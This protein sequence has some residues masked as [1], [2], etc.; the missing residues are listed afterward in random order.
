MVS[1]GRWI[2][3]AVEYLPSHVLPAATRRSRITPVTDD[4]RR[5]QLRLQRCVTL[6]TS[7]VVALA[8]A[9]P[10]KGID[11][12]PRWPASERCFG[13]I[14]HFGSA[15]ALWGDTP[16]VMTTDW[17]FLW[18]EILLILCLAALGQYAVAVRLRSTNRWP[19]RQSAGV[20]AV[21]GLLAFAGSVAYVPKTTHAMRGT[22]FGI[23]EA[24]GLRVT[25]L[26]VEVDSEPLRAPQ[27]AF[28]WDN[29]RGGSI[30]YEGSP[31]GHRGV[32]DYEYRVYWPWAAMQPAF[33]LFAWG[34]ALTWFVRRER[35]RR[36]LKPP[37]PQAS[38]AD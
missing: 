34:L 7:G 28:L 16:P 4:L 1:T 12:I 17:C 36:F 5:Y 20:L 9:F 18:F 33:A 10:P 21:A 3:R 29:G 23:S 25:H 31:L 13:P 24:G 6:V 38:G 22:H 2:G 15:P 37:G 30:V 11:F 26:D 32:Y 8:L 35:W 14:P 19:I 27:W